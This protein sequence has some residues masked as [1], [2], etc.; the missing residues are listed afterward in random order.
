MSLFCSVKAAARFITRKN[1]ILV[2]TETLSVLKKVSIDEDQHL[3]IVSI[4]AWQYDMF[5]F[6]VFCF[7]F[8]INNLRK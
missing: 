4:A 8:L 6:F 3:P 5:S 2:L 7:V 1:F